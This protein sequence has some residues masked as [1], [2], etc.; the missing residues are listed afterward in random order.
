M[1]TDFITVSHTIHIEIMGFEPLIPDGVTLN[2]LIAVLK[3]ESQEAFTFFRCT[4]GN[5]R[6]GQLTE[7]RLEPGPGGNV[8]AAHAAQQLFC[9][10]GMFSRVSCLT[11]EFGEIVR[12]QDILRGGIRKIVAPVGGAAETPVSRQDGF[13]I[14]VRLNEQLQVLRFIT[15][16]TRNPVAQ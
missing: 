15:C 14:I 4:R 7:D 2:N 10:S 12:W 9:Q 5:H 8:V 3:E 13:C 16:Y 11:E 1:L 6:P